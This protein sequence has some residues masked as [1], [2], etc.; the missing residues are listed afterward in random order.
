MEFNYDGVKKLFKSAETAYNKRNYIVNWKKEHN[1]QQKQY[2]KE[3][4]KEAYVK[5]KIQGHCDI[6][7]CDYSNK[8]YHMK[9][10]KHLNKLT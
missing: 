2:R 8:Y 1:E 3:Y 10:K 6:C 9:S 4:Y 5:H 7:N